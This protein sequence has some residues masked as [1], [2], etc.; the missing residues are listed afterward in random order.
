M[1]SPVRYHRLTCLRIRVKPPDSGT[2]VPLPPGDYTVRVGDSYSIEAR[3][4][5]GYVFS[6]WK[7]ND[8]SYSASPRITLSIKG[9]TTLTA[10]FEKEAIKRGE[11]A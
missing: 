6:R 10:V 7:L 8:V 9:P 3:P 5:R 1:K 11:E 4:N 2:T